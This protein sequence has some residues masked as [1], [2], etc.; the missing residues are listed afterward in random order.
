MVHWVTVHVP[1]Q[2]QTHTYIDTHT[3]THK[4]TGGIEAETVV[5]KVTKVL[6]I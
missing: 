4:R 6:T 2:T 1:L 3:H 5:L